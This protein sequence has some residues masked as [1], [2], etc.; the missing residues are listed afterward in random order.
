[1]LH[2]ALR[3]DDGQIRPLEAAFAAQ[4]MAA[5]TSLLAEQRRAARRVAL[6][7]AGAA[8]IERTHVGDNLPDLIAREEDAGHRR[9]GDAVRDVVEQV[10]GRT[11]VKE[12]A[13]LETGSAASFAFESVAF[14]A[15]RSKDFGS[16]GDVGGSGVRIPD[17]GF[18]AEGAGGDQQDGD[19]PHERG[20]SFRWAGSHCRSFRSVLKQY[21]DYLQ[22]HV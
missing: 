17:F 22:L 20:G 3:P 2:G 1:M 21:L 9:A 4:Q 11:S 14:G 7:A 12:D 15:V 18:L 16:G 10:G 8:L 6:G 13:G 19:N 5:D